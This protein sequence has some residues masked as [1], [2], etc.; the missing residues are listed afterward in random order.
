MRIKKNLLPAVSALFCSLLLT[1][2]CADLTV[3]QYR[4]TFAGER[5]VEFKGRNAET[6]NLRGGRTGNRIKILY[7]RQIQSSDKKGNS[8]EKI[9]IKQ[10]DY[11]KYLKDKTVLDFKS[12]GA[13]SKS[14]LGR[15]VG[16]S[17]TIES[18]SEGQ[19]NRVLDTSIDRQSLKGKAEQNKAAQ[20]LLETEAIKQ[21][22]SI[23][24]PPKNQQARMKVSDTWSNTKS[25]SFGTLGTKSYKRI[26]TVTKFDES[27]GRR[28]M[29]VDMQ[30][31]PVPKSQEQKKPGRWSNLSPNT[32]IYNG[33]M[34][35]DLTR[36]QT[37]KYIENCQI[38]WVVEDPNSTMEQDEQPD[39]MIMKAAHTYKVEMI[40]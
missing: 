15:L 5:S 2:G 35:F 34:T 31:I 1:T 39:A 10:L 13:D 26:Y 8:I 37:S 23:P 29:L 32:E 38:E 40:D 14:P 33:N 36:R 16:Q 27:D 9:T 30:G 18:G 21:L 17:I 28:I 6:R 7:S 25:F 20:K 24:A 3:S 11:L 19:I 12:K 22:Y 4:L